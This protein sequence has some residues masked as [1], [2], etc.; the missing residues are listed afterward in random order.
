MRVA[1]NLAQVLPGFIRL[2]IAFVIK[3]W[4][5]PSRREADRVHFLV[6][7]AEDVN[8][9]VTNQL[10]SCMLTLENFVNS[11]GYP[12]GCLR[13]RVSSKVT[14]SGLFFFQVA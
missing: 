8:G 4:R 12:Y 9:V 11:G 3:H 1:G 2:L 7:D 14:E 5:E 13:W 6:R 10:E